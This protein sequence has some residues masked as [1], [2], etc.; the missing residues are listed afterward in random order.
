M[1]LT[2]RLDEEDYL[3]MLHKLLITLNFNEIRKAHSLV[4][5][6]AIRKGI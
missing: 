4:C 6:G 5:D 3:K 2:I 1:L